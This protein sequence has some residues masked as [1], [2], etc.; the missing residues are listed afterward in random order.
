M[1][2]CYNTGEVKAVSRNLTADVVDPYVGGLCG[3]AQNN[4][5]SDCYNVG[6]LKTTSYNSN[7]SY[8][9]NM[10]YIGGL[11]GY[12]GKLSFTRCFN[13][14][15]ANKGSTYYYWIGGIVGADSGRA[16]TYTNTYWPYYGYMEGVE[17]VF[18]SSI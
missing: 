17:N 14:G 3:W 8:R 18:K 5:F 4:S 7:T 9:H 16:S 6:G 2:Q 15:Y 12:G 13:K 10:V 1:N 11:V